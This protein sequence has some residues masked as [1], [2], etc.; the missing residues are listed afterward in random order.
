ME[1][2]VIIQQGDCLQVLRGMPDN[3][4]DCCVTSPP[5]FGLRDYQEV[6]QIGQ[7]STPKMYVDKIVEVFREVRRVLCGHGTLWLNLGDSYAG[8]WGNYGGQNRGKGTQREIKNGSTVPNPAYDGLE[9][10]RPPTA[11]QPGYKPKDLIGIPWMVAFALR[12]DGWYLRMDCIWSKPNPMPELV[13][14][15]PTKSHEY[16]FLLSKSNRYYYDSFSI[17]EPAK[18]SSIKR[19]NQDVESQQGSSRVPGKTNGPMKAAGGPR[20]TDK[21]R[22]HSRR[23]EGFNDRWDAMDKTQQQQFGANKRSVWTVGTKGFKGAHFAVFPPKLIE[24]CILAGCP[25]TVCVECGKP[26]KRIVESNRIPTRPGRDTKVTGNSLVDGNR[27]PQRHITN[28]K[29]LGF[30]ADCECNGK[31]RKGVVLDPFFGS[32]TTAMVAQELGRDCIGIELNPEYIAMAYERV[33]QSR[34]F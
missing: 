28:T 13:T 16:L 34:L 1:K 30:A 31:T 6:G 20:R 22:G 15:R 11:S 5:Y 33:K 2:R 23:H 3:S 8:S 27:D 24:P 4:V 9:S 19:W 25:E 29:D 7:E 26:W 17:R 12:N 14:D 32:G 18:E 10:F 21:Q